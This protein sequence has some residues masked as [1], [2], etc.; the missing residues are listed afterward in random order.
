MYG[1]I[2]KYANSCRTLTTTGWEAIAGTPTAAGTW[3][4]ANFM[5]INSDRN[6][7]NIRLDSNITDISSERLKK[8]RKIGK[9]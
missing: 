9:N 3:A 1:S 4:T 6:I 2:S 5:D 7:S 8:N